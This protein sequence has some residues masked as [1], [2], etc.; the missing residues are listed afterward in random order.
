MNRTSSLIQAALVLKTL[1]TMQAAKV[2]ARLEPNDI[3]SV[4]D[5]VEGLDESS[6][7]YLSDAVDRLR[8]ETDS[9]KRV[10]GNHE[11]LDEAN[12]KIEDLL[13]REPVNSERASQEAP[14]EFLCDMVPVVRAH[15]LQDEHPRNI[16]IALSQM[17][18]KVASETMKSFDDCQLRVS[19][20]KRMCELDEVNREEMV[21]LEFAL[22]QRLKN[23]LFARDLDGD[24]L[25]TAIKMLSCSDAPSRESLLGHFNQVD[26]DLANK[27][28]RSVFGVE[29]LEEL[30]KE[31][32]QV[33]LR[34][35]DTSSWAPAL[36]NASSSV[37]Q[38]V[39]SA[40]APP[41]IE[42]LQREIDELG[43]VDRALEDLS[44]QNIVEAILELARKGKVELR[45]T[46]RVLS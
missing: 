12:R 32:L 16:A 23:L 1:P 9:W 39:Y 2:I 43:I 44:R 45:K 46:E 36:K 40:M 3:K 10:G 13:E 8:S 20:L 15:V 31:E 17:P 11:G 28:Q 21:Q 22:R 35:V 33:V 14:F 5:A 34:N 38:K 18:P 42:L 26:P 27:I 19:V 25:E 37:Q 24:G 41:V 30:S 6:A 7:S 4:L 29:K